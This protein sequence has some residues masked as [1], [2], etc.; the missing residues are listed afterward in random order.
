VRAAAFDSVEDTGETIGGEKQV[1]VAG[2]DEEEAEFV[3][4]RCVLSEKGTAIRWPNCSGLCA[5][6]PAR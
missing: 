6:L 3:M 1:D 2:H 4:A 5:E